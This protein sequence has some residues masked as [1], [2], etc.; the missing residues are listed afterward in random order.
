MGDLILHGESYVAIALYDAASRFFAT[1][2][3]RTPPPPEASQ[4]G[5]MRC[6]STA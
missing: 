2:V 6:P 4:I 1:H 3:G 5:G